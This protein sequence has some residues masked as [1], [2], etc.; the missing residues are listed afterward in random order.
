MPSSGYGYSVWYVPTNYKEL[1]TTYGI[2][3]VPHVTLE[4]NLLLKDAFH[5]HKHAIKNIV[6]EYCPKYVEF[7]QCYEHD[8]LIA[9]GWYVNVLELKGR[10][11]HWKPH[12]SIQYFQRK[13]KNI[14]KKTIDALPPQGKF[15]CFCVLADTRSI[16]PFEWSIDKR[17]F[18]LKASNGFVVDMNG[19]NGT[20]RKANSCDEYFGFCEGVDKIDAH[21]QIKDRLYNV[22][23][24]MTGNDIDLII[25]TML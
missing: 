20:L 7:P 14:I 4:T 5:I 21:K 10:K 2:T 1:Q 17:Y 25:D 15:E 6:I 3:H 8:P 19:D 18:N 9:F 13:D 22:G 16:N 12:M 24:R 11:E 23:V